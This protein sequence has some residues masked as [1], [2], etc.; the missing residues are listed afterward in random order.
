M[1]YTEIYGFDVKGN[2][3]KAAEIHNAW[4]G[5]MAIWHY[6]EDTYLPPF[7]PFYIQ[8]M[9]WYHREMTEEELEKRCAFKP[10]RLQPLGIDDK[11]TV[12]DIWNLAYDRNVPDKDRI[13]LLTTFDKILV[14]KENMPY[15]IESFLAFN[16]PNTSLIEQAEILKQLFNSSD[17]I[18]V[19]WNQNSVCVESWGNNFNRAKDGEYSPYNC[20][21]QNEHQWLPFTEEQERTMHE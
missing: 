14:K 17:C 4:R 10:S 3:Y 20:L 11:D 2:A 15:V 13:V 1:S 7:I 12:N 18:A 19:G 9:P 16:A 8:H 5:A 6:L 21:Q